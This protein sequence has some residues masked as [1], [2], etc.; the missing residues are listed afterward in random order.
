MSAFRDEKYEEYVMY[1]RW[2]GAPCQDYTNKTCHPGNPRD[3][4]WH[5]DCILQRVPAMTV[6]TGMPGRSVARVATKDLSKPW[7]PRQLTGIS[8]TDKLHATYDVYTNMAF[9]TGDF[10]Q[11]IQGI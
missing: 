2:D 6:R 8:L 10:H 9:Q 1:V 3:H 4:C 7:G 5:L 11:G